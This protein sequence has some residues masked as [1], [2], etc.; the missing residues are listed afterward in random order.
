M[1]NTMTEFA[2]GWAIILDR[3]I[4][5]RS[6]SP[7]RVGAIVNWLMTD[8][9]ILVPDSLSNSRIEEYWNQNKGKA[10]CVEVNI[11]VK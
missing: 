5:I 4:N 1:E 9:H 8:A 11:T 2:T 6:V 7:T 3:K 10:E